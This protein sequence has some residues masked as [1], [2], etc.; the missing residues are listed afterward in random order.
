MP[1]LDIMNGLNVR[2]FKLM[3]V[4]KKNPRKLQFV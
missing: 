3:I 1:H 2:A 4:A